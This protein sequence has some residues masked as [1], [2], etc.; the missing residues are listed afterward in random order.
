MR[1][2]SQPPRCFDKNKKR[3]SGRRWWKWWLV[4]VTPGCARHMADQ[5]E[6]GFCVMGV[7]T[8]GSGPLP[9][10]APLSG[11][12]VPL[13][14][15][16]DCSCRLHVE[17]RTK[18]QAPALHSNINTTAAGPLILADGP[19]P[20]RWF[21]AGPTTTCPSMETLSIGLN[22]GRT[23]LEDQNLDQ[24]I[25]RREDGPVELNHSNK[26]KP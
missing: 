19:L 22:H 4:A 14:S 25:C 16:C 3:A 7:R 11:R 17:C 12:A 9:S 6:E 18:G 20:R 21:D 23:T 2:A 10:R 8:F 15:L 1:S 24:Q 26:M 5:H 13:C